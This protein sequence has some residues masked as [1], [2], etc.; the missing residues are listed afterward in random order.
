M[1]IAT[2]EKV[3]YGSQVKDELRGLMKLKYPIVRGQIQTIS[4]MDMMWQYTYQELK[5]NFKDVSGGGFCRLAST[6]CC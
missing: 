4:E 6:R 1:P 3:F 2:Q 5:S